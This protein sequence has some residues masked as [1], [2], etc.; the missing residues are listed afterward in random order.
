MNRDE[1]NPQNTQPA[2]L[3]CTL[4]DPLEL[5]LA[6]MPFLVDGGLFIPVT[7][8]YVLGDSVWVDLVLPGRIESIR[9]E[10][11]VVWITPKNALHHVLPGIGIQ[12]V[13]PNAKTVKSQIESNLDSSYDIGG[14]TY[15]ITEPFKRE[16]K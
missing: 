13:G 8:N 10:G 16:T 7:G 5:N 12:F 4:K 15:G 9:I 3:T 6:Y 11:K 2:V 14:Y 1:K